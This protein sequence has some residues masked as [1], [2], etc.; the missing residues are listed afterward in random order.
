MGLAPFQCGRF[1]AVESIEP[2]LTLRPP[3]LRITSN[4]L[5]YYTVIGMRITSKGQVTI[6]QAVRERFGFLPDTEVTFE[7]EDGQVVLRKVKGAGHQ[8]RAL[9]E[10]MRGRAEVRLSTDAIM[11]LSRDE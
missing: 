10:R 6:P 4:T 11:A 7:V 2:G 1:P 9:V 3:S 8:G 5:W